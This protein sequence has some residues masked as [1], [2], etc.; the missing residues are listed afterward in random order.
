[1]QLDCATWDA[2]GTTGAESVLTFHA[3]LWDDTNTLLEGYDGNIIGGTRLN[4]QGT[5][6]VGFAVGFPPTRPANVNWTLKNMTLN[7]LKP[8][9]SNLII[10]LFT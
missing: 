4:R 7:V 2:D 9:Q 1:V 10:T 6:L 3:E 8:F 5:T